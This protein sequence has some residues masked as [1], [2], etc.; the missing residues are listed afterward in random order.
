MKL[1]FQTFWKVVAICVVAMMISSQANASDPLSPDRLVFNSLP[2]PSADTDGNGEID[3]LDV[4]TNIPPSTDA[5]VY[6]GE[7][8][9]DEVYTRNAAGVPVVN[10]LS[11]GVNRLE[12]AVILATELDVPLFLKG[13]FAMTGAIR[14]R[15]SVSIS[16]FS[17]S[18][19]VIHSIIDDGTTLI[20]VMN[21][22]TDVTIKDLALNEVVDLSTSMLLMSG[23]NERI[24]IDNVDFVGQRVGAIYQTTAAILMSRDWIKD[25]LITNCDISGFQY[26]IH[27][28]S[29]VRRLR[30]VNNQ[31]SQ[32][33][34]FALRIARL[35]SNEHLR[36]EDISVIG[37]DFRSP[38]RGLF[39]SVI[40]ITRGESL[41][42]IRDVNVNKN[43]I[44][45][46]GGSFQRNDTTSNATGDQI[47]L[48]GVNGFQ[49]T[50]NFVFHGGENGITASTLSRNGIISRNTIHGNDTHGINIG[51]GL[52]ELSVSSAANI[53]KN[54]RIGGIDS[55]AQATVRSIRI[56][57]ADGRIVL[58]LERITGGRIFRNEL[59][60][61]L[62]TGRKK[63]AMTRIVDRTKNIFVFENLISGNGL[64]QAN[65]TPYTFGIFVQNADT[66][67]IVGNRIQ[68][69]NYRFVRAFGG[70]QDQRQSVF[71]ANSRD[72]F[73][74]GS[75]QFEFGFETINQALGMNASSWLR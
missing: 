26:G 31:F 66:I 42:Y 75:N 7:D 49:V 14:I 53:K 25:V 20:N 46:D 32:W 71:L 16:G 64:D 60:D 40:F 27:C 63:I 9:E 10:Y 35:H 72:V 43:T 3:V 30:I 52:Y 21:S 70:V 47:V 67:D 50:G 39:K 36:S 58:G 8:S 44:F 1:F 56:H 55:G 45:S 54:H 13:H 34:S 57:P 38:S 19:T 18:P 73:V 28:V 24:L 65:N 62:T 6:F 15:D 17:S 51:S 48:H 5:I 69:P 37:N 41:L 59:L 22:A 4:L 68:N 61:N 11:E 33:S 2:T 23:L 74:S 12:D 29:G